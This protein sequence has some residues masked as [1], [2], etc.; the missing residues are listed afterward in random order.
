MSA[1]ISRQLA[2]RYYK[3]AATSADLNASPKD[4]VVAALHMLALAIAG[5]SASKREELL[6]AIERDGAL[7]EAG[8][9][10][11]TRTLSRP[12]WNAALTP[13]PLGT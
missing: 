2:G 1:H 5:L 12:L 9:D 6:R 11:H 3:V 10:E 4:Y 8:A 7:R 13:A